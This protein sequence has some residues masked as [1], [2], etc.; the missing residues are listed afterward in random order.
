MTTFQPNEIIEEF[1]NFIHFSCLNGGIA[2]EQFGSL[3]KGII[4]MYF[5]AR[6]V[7]IDYERSVVKA[8]IPTSDFAYT[9]VN[10]ECQDLDKFL[11]SCIKKDKRSLNFYQSSL[12]YY[13]HVIHQNTEVAQVA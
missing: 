9:T 8:E 6:K 5:G 10:F 4:K 11:S 12:N 7:E 1:K 13:S 3:H 2:N